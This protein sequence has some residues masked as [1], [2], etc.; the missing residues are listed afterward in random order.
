LGHTALV[1]T[2]EVSLV[3]ASWA[4]LSHLVCPVSAVILAIAEQPFRDASVVGRT[5]ASSPASC[6]VSVAA[7]VSWLVCVIPTVVVVVTVPQLWNAL[8]VSA[9][10]FS[11]IIAGPLVAHVLC[12]VRAIHTVG[13]SI[14]LPGTK[15][16]TTGLLALELVLRTLMIAIFL[17][18]PIPTI[19]PPIADCS[20]K[21]AII[22]LTLELTVPALSL[23]A[24]SRLV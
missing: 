3:L 10:E 8:S 9:L 14:T 13:I 22:V 1:S 16:A 7:E 11:L 21:G 17:I 23:R 19:V 5:W 24:R 20:D 4:V 15:D 6:A 18:T 2:S 12:F